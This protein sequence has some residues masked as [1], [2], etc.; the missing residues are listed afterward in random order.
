[1]ANQEDN[2]NKRINESVENDNEDLDSTVVPEDY[3]FPSWFSFIAY[4]PFVTK[5]QR[6]SLFE[7]NVP[8]I[9]LSSFMGSAHSKSQNRPVNGT[10][11]NLS[12]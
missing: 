4:G 7:I 12:I 9:A 5:D 2:A 10:S 8:L 11:L 1:M 6:L 3:F